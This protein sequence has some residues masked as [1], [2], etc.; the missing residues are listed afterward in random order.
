M[1]L[2]PGYKNLPKDMRLL[3]VHL[4]QLCPVQSSG[5][6]PPPCALTRT[7]DPSLIC[8]EM[9]ASDRASLC[10]HSVLCRMEVRARLI[11]AKASSVP[12]LVPVLVP[13]LG[14]THIILRRALKQGLAAV[15]WF[16]GG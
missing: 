9:Q 10:L 3:A 5:P 14:H 1:R 2:T 8:E 13:A 11:F 6:S 4:G 7:K 16:T 15:D 12:A